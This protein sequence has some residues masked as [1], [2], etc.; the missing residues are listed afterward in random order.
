MLKYL[1]ILFLFILGCE[2]STSSSENE[3]VL[4]RISEELGIKISLIGKTNDSENIRVFD[5]EGNDVPVEVGYS[6]F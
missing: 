1:F 4:K 6:H 3:A 2:S 5:N